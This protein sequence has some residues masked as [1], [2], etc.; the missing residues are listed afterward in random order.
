MFNLQTENVRKR[1]YLNMMKTNLRL[2]KKN[3][4]KKFTIKKKIKKNNKK[5]PGSEK[6]ICVIHV[7]VIIQ[8]NVP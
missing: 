3:C 6:K 4:E 5:S 1:S 8:I 2:E 7:I